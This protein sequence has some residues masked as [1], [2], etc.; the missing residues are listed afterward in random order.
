M[1]PA[2]IN[3][4]QKAGFYSRIGISDNG[5]GFNK[6]YPDR[7]FKVF[8]RLHGKQKFA[9]TGIGLAICHRV[10]GKPY[11]CHFGRIIPDSVLTFGVY[12]PQSKQEG[13]NQSINRITLHVAG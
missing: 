12:F 7:I 1:R 2:H 5:I 13:L 10:G 11:R 6:L 3:P 9:G 8:Q 4:S